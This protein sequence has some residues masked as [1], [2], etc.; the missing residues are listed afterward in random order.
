MQIKRI[1]PFEYGL[2]IKLF[3]EY[4]MF[5][6]QS[7]DISLAENFIKERLQNNESVIFV[8]LAD[9]D[10]RQIPV[11]FTQLYPLISSMRAIKNW[12]LNDL[13]VDEVYR[14]QGIGAALIKAAIQFS[15]TGNA[16]FIQL[17]TA[18]DNYNAQRLYENIGFKKHEPGSA[19]FIYR[20]GL[21]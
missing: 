14:K 19:F 7:S 9:E 12:V 5:Y 3:D 20:A 18:F 17:E 10:S 2:V 16:R 6:G 15:K 8:A 11:G 4:R 13:Y 21:D 1:A